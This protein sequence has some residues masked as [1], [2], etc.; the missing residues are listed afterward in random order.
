MR[1]EAYYVKQFPLEIL[2]SHF[3]DV[4]ALFVSVYTILKTE[5]RREHARSPQ[6]PLIPANSRY[7]KST[8]VVS[9]LG[10]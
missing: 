9:F 7:P 3:P 6:R 10:V 1:A 8:T 2:F 5:Q 4:P